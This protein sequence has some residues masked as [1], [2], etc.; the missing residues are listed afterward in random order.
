MHFF[1]SAVFFFVIATV[2]TRHVWK[3]ALQ[4]LSTEGYTNMKSSWCHYEKVMLISHDWK[5]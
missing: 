4:E 1:L 2:K 5:T 3:R